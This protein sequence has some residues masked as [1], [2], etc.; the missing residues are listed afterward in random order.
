[1]CKIKFVRNY[2]FFFISLVLAS[3]SNSKQVDLSK[4][5]LDL[6]VER[7]DKDM[8]KLT[9]QNLIKLA[10]QLHRQY[11]NF[12]EDYMS[13]MISAGNPLD[14]LYYKNLRTILANKDYIELKN[15]VQKAY[16]D[17]SATETQLTDA[18]KHIK[19]YYPQTKVPRIISFLSGFAVQ[20]PIGD[21]YIGI[22]LDMFLGADSK[23]YPALRESIPLYISHRFTQQNIVPRVMETYIREDLY[24]EKETKTLLDRMIY[25]GKVMYIMQATMPNV[26][27]S[28]L[29]GYTDKQMKWCT[30]FE[31]GVWGYFLE[32]NLLYE[33]D[34]MK[35]QHYLTEAPFTPELG[36]KNDSAPKLGI[37]TGWQIVKKYMDNNSNVTLQ[38]LVAETDYQKILKQSKY[39]PK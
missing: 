6:K 21:N 14:T 10:P 11:S 36:E 33:T 5:K 32:N 2:W 20:T 31:A 9:A 22:G 23:F 38:Q 1:M 18:F 4:I 28:V 35:I 29:I 24:P 16:P 19:Y 15:S 25:N 12:Y 39:K 34:Y 37:Y 8:D 17:L 13:K 3:C 27:D 30:S 7:F 26:A